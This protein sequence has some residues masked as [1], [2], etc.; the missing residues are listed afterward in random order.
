MAKKKFNNIYSE[1]EPLWKY[2]KG[3][4][5]WTNIITADDYD[6]W[7]TNFYG[8]EVED[9]E[10]ELQAYLDEAVEFAKKEGKVVNTIAPLYKEYEGKK[11]IQFKKKKY[12]EDT[13]APK[14]YNITGEETTG[15][16]KSEP[17]GGSTLRLRAMVKPYYMASTK[18]VGLTYGMLAVQIIENKQYQGASGFEDESTSTAE[19]PPFEMS[20]DY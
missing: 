2:V 5:Q 7:S 6:K 16:L 18:T 4:G 8:Q 12:D 15:N 20:E 17:G 1:T 3:I 10:V 19:T 11:Y 9:L 14:T 13:E